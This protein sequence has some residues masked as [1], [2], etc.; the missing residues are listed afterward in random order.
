MKVYISG[1]TRTMYREIKETAELLSKAGHSATYYVRGT[2]YN[3]TLL[4]MADAVVF[5]L[6]GLSWETPLRKLTQCSLKELI[7]CLNNKKDFYIAYKTFDGV[8]NIYA[9][10][11]NE[12]LCIKGTDS[13]YMNLDTI[14]DILESPTNQETYVTTTERFY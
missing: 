1:C 8:L 2:V 13:T 3:K 7:Y 4:E 10:Q 12:D 11:I 14:N 5:V 9:A 6:P